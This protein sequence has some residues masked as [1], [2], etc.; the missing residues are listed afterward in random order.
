MATNRIV[1]IDGQITLQFYEVGKWWTCSKANNN[2]E[3]DFALWP[4]TSSNMRKACRLVQCEPLPV[5]ETPLKPVEVDGWWYASREDKEPKGY[6]DAL[7]LIA[8]SV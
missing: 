2:D 5:V 7:R 4:D 6:G 8:R 1:R 3:G